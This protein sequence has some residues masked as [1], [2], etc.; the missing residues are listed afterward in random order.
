VIVTTEDGSIYRADYVMVSVSL[1][2]L[3]TNLIKFQPD[4]PVS[5]K[6]LMQ[7][8]QQNSKHYEI[9]TYCFYS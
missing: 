3:Q 5:F 2:V 9:C 8:E 1:G 7:R 6:K 4:L